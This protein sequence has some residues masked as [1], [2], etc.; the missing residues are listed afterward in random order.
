MSDKALQLFGPNEIAWAGR[1]AALEDDWVRQLTKHSQKL[2]SHPD[3]AALLWHWH[4]GLIDPGGWTVPDME[5][6]PVAEEQ[7]LACAYGLLV[8]SGIH[9][10]NEVYTS[11]G[12]SD[13]IIQDT[14][15]DV[16]R[17]FNTCLESLGCPGVMRMRWLTHHLTHRIV[18]LGRLQFEMGRVDTKLD[19]AERDELQ[20]DHACIR[21]LG[22][23]LESPVLW[24]HIPRSGPLIPE[25]CE[26]SFSQ[27]TSFFPVHFPHH[28]AKAMLCRSWL[29][30]PQLAEY[31]PADSNICRFLK[32]FELLGFE[33]DSDEVQ[34][35]VFGQV[36]QDI[37]QAPQR[38]TLDRAIVKHLKRG[39]V[40]RVGL[41]RL[42]A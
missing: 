2:R 11:H 27:A 42:K 23:T 34:S 39:G 5:Q 28:R 40:W 36:Y 35:F 38:T 37:T 9:R 8:L 3:T 16:H 30:D 17:A 18:E 13:T 41:G 33:R 32:R 14:L 31:L 24:I 6:W 26:D 10:F 29:M 21:R 25:A 19:E 1:M 7:E 20:S 22:L 12:I 4:R 15:R